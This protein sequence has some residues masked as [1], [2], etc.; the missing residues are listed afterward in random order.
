MPGDGCPHGGVKKMGHTAE[1]IKTVTRKFTRLQNMLHDGRAYCCFVWDYL[2]ELARDYNDCGFVLRT[3]MDPVYIGYRNLRV[4]TMESYPY[5]SLPAMLRYISVQAK[6]P[7]F[8]V[9]RVSSDMACGPMTVP[10]AS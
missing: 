2:G 3:S 6:D 4:S 1:R 9:F 5:T 8:L 10:I 7:A